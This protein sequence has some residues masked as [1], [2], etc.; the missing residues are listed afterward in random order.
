VTKASDAQQ[1]QYDVLS[2]ADEA[3]AGDLQQCC[4][5]PR[6]GRYEPSAGRGDGRIGLT[7]LAMIFR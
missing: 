3:A 1:W 7:Q 4:S 2:A 6:K 5:I